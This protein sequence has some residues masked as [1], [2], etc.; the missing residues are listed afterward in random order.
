[1]LHHHPALEGISEMIFREAMTAVEGIRDYRLAHPE[2]GIPT[3]A[4]IMTR[5][6]KR[7]CQHIDE[8]EVTGNTRIKNMK[9]SPYKSPTRS[10]QNASQSSTSSQS[11]QKSKIPKTSTRQPRRT[12]RTKAIFTN[13]T[14]P[15][16]NDGANDNM[17]IDNDFFVQQN[18]NLK[19]ESI[20]SIFSSITFFIRNISDPSVLDSQK[21]RQNFLFSFFF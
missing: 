8:K 10:V 20:A 19:N 3:N 15:S 9:E 2:R 7:L 11:E 4:S 6:W 14:D 16:S 17:K 12:K 13:E 5:D 1:M 18:L 21:S